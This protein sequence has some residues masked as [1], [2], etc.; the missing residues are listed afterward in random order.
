MSKW[1][2]TDGATGRLCILPA[3]PIVDTR[4][5]YG[6]VIHNEVECNGI[7]EAMRILREYEYDEEKKSGGTFL[8]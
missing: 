5:Q 1:V 7:L 8:A 2:I 3:G 6:C 4:S